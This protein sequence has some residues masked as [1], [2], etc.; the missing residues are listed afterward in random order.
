VNQS[1]SKPNSS[2]NHGNSSFF[3]K[4]SDSKDKPKPNLLADKLGKNG[5]LTGEERERRMKE[6]LCLYCGKSGH[7]AHDCPK[8]VAAKARAASVESKDSADSKK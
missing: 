7:V 6:G 2:A 5:K 3:G 1:V 4:K 8:S